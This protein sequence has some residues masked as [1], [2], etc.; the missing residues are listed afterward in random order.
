MA[1]ASQLAHRLANRIQLGDYSVKPLPAERELAEQVGV[2]RMTARKALLDLV[3]RG[4]I[5]RR[6]NGRLTVAENADPAARPRIALLKP[7]TAGTSLMQ[8]T[9]L[10]LSARTDTR[11]RIIEFAHWDDPVIADA[12]TAF[13]GLFVLPPAEPLPDPLLDRLRD[14]AAGVVVLNRDTSDDGLRCVD[15][16]PPACIATLMD[17]F[18]SFGHR[19][20]DCLNTQPC[21]DTITARIDA[22]R[23]WGVAHDL[24][25]GLINRPVRSYDNPTPAAYRC[26]DELLANGKPLPSGLLCTTT[27]AAVAVMRRLSEAGL[28]VGRDISVAAIDDEGLNQFLRPSLTCLVPPDPTPY[29]RRCLDWM[30]DGGRPADWDGPLLLRPE[31]IE[32]FAGESVGL[33]V[34][35]HPRP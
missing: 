29:V 8:R 2:S 20:V 15:T 14:A 23:R 19:R 34:S 30:L 3:D 21:D 5:E 31:S 11:V 12:I 32:L 24:P 9:L 33:S 10:R 26:I 27:P 1:A 22:W 13:D 25:G 4:L 6:E 7:A 16:C 35:S 17:H 18:R 28:E